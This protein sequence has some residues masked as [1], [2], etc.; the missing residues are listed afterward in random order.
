[1]ESGLPSPEFIKTRVIFSFKL[2]ANDF[3]K[4]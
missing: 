4:P 2:H 1:M 3:T